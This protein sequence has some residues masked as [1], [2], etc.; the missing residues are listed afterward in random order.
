MMETL[1]LPDGTQAV[2]IHLVITG[3]IPCQPGLTNLSGKMR[4]E[5]PRA[6]NCPAC[7]QAADSVMRTAFVPGPASIAAQQTIPPVPIAPRKPP[8]VLPV[9]AP[10]I[11]QFPGKDAE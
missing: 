7:M 9:P 5:D 10:V 2:L 11:I 1:T 6:I 3:C 4:S 8:I